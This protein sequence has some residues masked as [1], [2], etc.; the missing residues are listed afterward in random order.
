[1]DTNELICRTETDL[2]TLKT[3]LQLPKGA[4]CGG[5]LGVWDW[6]MHT[7]VYEM[8]GQWGPSVEH[9]ELYQIFCDNQ[10]GK[11]I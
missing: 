5:G 6:H 11:R 2:P 1:M 4:G 9:R 10:C 3:N 8:I 7:E